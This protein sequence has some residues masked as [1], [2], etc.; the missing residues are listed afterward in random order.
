MAI[1]VT[2]DE[3]DLDVALT[4]IAECQKLGQVDKYERARK[5]LNF[6]KADAF[7]RSLENEAERIPYLLHQQAD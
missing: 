6:A 5:R 3:A 1:K 2:V 7:R 4:A